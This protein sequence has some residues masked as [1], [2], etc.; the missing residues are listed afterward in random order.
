MA[1][2][3]DAHVHRFGDL[4]AISLPGKGATVYLTVTEAQQLARALNRCARDVKTEPR[5]S[6]SR[7]AS[8]SIP[9]ANPFR[10]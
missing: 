5:F 3:K 8:V 9:V 6:V 10:E 2:L 7:F 1:Q 4:T